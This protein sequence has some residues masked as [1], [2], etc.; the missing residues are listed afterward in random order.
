MSEVAALIADLV[1]AGVSPGLVG[2]VAAALASREVVAVKLQDEAAERRRARD[3]EY[4]RGRRGGDVGRSRPISAE[5][6]DLSPPSPLSPTPPI[7][8]TNPSP[9][10]PPKGGSV[11]HRKWPR[12]R[13][14][15][16]AWSPL[17]EDL[18]VGRE[19]GLD[20]AALARAL[21]MMRDHEFGR[22]RTDWSA[23]YRNWLRNEIRHER[24]HDRPPP[25]SRT[26]RVTANLAGALLG[27]EA[28]ARLRAG[29]G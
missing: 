23:V 9:P 17:P 3:R 4:R 28:A 29:R 22:A 11:P 15:P 19:L 8:T 24:R 26:D 7:P 12:S 20:E 21:A 10:S 5:S 27:A 6:D 2:R 16:A 18:Q 25:V 13:R 14:M 1:Q